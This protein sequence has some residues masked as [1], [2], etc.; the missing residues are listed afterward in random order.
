MRTTLEIVNNAAVLLHIPE[1]HGNAVRILFGGADGPLG[2]IDSNGQIKVVPSQGP[3]DPE[4]RKAIS[5]ILRGVEVLGR[6]AG[7]ANAV[8]VS[9]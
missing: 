8:G 6:F 1:E 3:G 2:T 4:I 5:A 9:G 7:G